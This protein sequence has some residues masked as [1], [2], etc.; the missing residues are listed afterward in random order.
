MNILLFVLFI[1][2]VVIYVVFRLI[3]LM[4][5]FVWGLVIQ[6]IW[7]FLNF[8]YMD[9]AFAGGSATIIHFYISVGLMVLWLLFT[10][11]YA[12]FCFVLASKMGREAKESK[13]PGETMLQADERIYIEYRN[14]FCAKV[15]DYFSNNKQ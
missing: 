7:F 13:L 1:L 14:R 5:A 11:G 15:R 12:V 9:W 4:R 8:K 6:A 10:I 3:R 2:F